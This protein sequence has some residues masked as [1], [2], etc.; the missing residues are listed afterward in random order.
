MTDLAFLA[1]DQQMRAREFESDVDRGQVTRS[2]SEGRGAASPARWT[3]E[4]RG[5]AG[6]AAAGC[7]GAARPVMPIERTT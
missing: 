4:G 1:R 7:G 2:A 3:V 5:D 6:G